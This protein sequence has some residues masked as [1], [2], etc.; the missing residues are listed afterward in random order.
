MTKHYGCGLEKLLLLLTWA[1][2]CIGN[3]TGC[4]CW[5]VGLAC[6]QNQQLQLFASYYNLEK[7]QEA[8]SYKHSAT[9]RVQ[10][11][12]H[13]SS[14]SSEV[15]LFLYHLSNSNEIKDSF[16]TKLGETKSRAA[17]E[18]FVQAVLQYER[19]AA[20]FLLML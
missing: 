3:S 9:E 16:S 15:N 11:C 20:V 10:Y 6:G 7:Q 18:A 19:N 14:T 13:S 4:S 12:T 8:F 1:Q 5:T 17:A 2:G